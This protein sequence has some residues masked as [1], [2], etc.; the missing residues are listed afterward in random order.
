MPVQLGEDAG[1]AAGCPDE[2]SFGQTPGE[3]AMSL[4]NQPARGRACLE[5]RMAFASLSLG[6]RD[7]GADSPVVPEARG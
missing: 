3:E 4:G 6:P 5:L 2:A 1:A 7:E